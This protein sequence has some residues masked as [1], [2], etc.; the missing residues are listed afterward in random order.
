MSVDHLSKTSCSVGDA[1]RGKLGDLV[2][3]PLPVKPSAAKTMKKGLK[4]TKQKPL[5]RLVAHSI[6]N[7]AVDSSAP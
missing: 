7:G 6:I 5:T 3:D 4:S 2:S 1:D